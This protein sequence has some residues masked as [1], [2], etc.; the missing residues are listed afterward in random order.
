MTTLT[1]FKQSLI[2]SATLTIMLC[3]SHSFAEVAQANIAN[4]V[5]TTIAQAP[6]QVALAIGT[7]RSDGSISSYSRFCA[8]TLISNQWIVSAA[9]C[10]AD[11]TLADNQAY[12]AI[13]GQQNLS[14]SVPLSAFYPISSIVKRSDYDAN[15]FNNDISLI[16]LSSAINLNTCN[17]CKV[18]KWSNNDADSTVNSSVFV[19][20]WGATTTAAASTTLQSTNLSIVNCVSN[21]TGSSY[22]IGNNTPLSTNTICA[23]S[24][25]TP[26]SDTC[27]GDSGSGLIGKYGTSNA[28][29]VGITSFS[30]KGTNNSSFCNNDPNYPGGYTKVSNYCQWIESVT[31]LS[32]NCVATNQNNSS[33]TQVVNVSQNTATSTT[34]TTSGGGGGGGSIGLGSLLTLMLSA[35]WMRRLRQQR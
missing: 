18:A 2:C 27:P 20:G 34:A 29:L 1:L 26:R 4:G 3:S 8:G 7:K 6:W 21:S 19:A 35:V 25:A 11:R 12:Y 5:D 13:I 23:Q 31:G 33:S 15:N 10:F 32:N 9:H 14:D 16:K 24:T 22:T 17:G 28:T 30:I